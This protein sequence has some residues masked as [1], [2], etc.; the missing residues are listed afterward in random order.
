MA[1][2]TQCAVNA[3][4]EGHG[5]ERVMAAVV[6]D[7]TDNTRN[8]GDGM[9]T[10]ISDMDSLFQ[11]SIDMIRYARGFAVQ[12]TNMIELMTNYTLGCWIVEEEQKGKDRA[13]YGAQVIDRLAE[14]LTGEFGRGY[15]RKTL[16]SARKF[17][18][19]YKDRISQTLFTEFAVKRSQ[20]PFAEPESPPFKLPWSQYLILMRIKDEKERNFYEAEAARGGWSIRTLKE[21]HAASL[22]ERRLLSPDKKDFPH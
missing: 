13:R 3:D 19:L 5:G 6:N 22:Y 17:F 12:H 18:L 16:R 11:N 15:S 9:A 8:L 14:V 4:H 20:A 7:V 10:D 1:N 21:Q 2:E